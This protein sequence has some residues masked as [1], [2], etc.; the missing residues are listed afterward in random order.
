MAHNSRVTGVAAID[1]RR[2]VSTGWDKALRIWNIEDGHL[3]ASMD[4]EDIGL[5]VAVHNS[6]DSVVVLGDQS[7]L[8]TFS[9]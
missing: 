2:V 7:G 5:S 8:S 4:L 1:K 9:K 6:V 3:L